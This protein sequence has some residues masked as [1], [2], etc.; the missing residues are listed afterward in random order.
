MQALTSMWLAKCSSS[1][2]RSPVRRLTTPPGRSLVPRTSDKVTAL[3]GLDVDASAMQVL[4][5][6]MVGAM[7]DKRP[8]RPVFSGERIDTTPVGS[9]KLKLKWLELTGL[10]LEKICWYLS[11]QP[12]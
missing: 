10:T 5:P 8:R 9:S 3:R 7:T 6:A 4:P 1:S 12:A 11:H 2:F